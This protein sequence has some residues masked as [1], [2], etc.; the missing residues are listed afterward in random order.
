MCQVSWKLLLLLLQGQVTVHLTHVSSSFCIDGNRVSHHKSQNYWRHCRSCKVGSAC[1]E[2]GHL[3][4]TSGWVG[5]LR[6]YM[7]QHWVSHRQ[8]RA[9]ACYAE[10]IYYIFSAQK[11]L[12]GSSFLSLT[13]AHGVFL[14]F[15]FKIGETE[16][17]D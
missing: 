5:L 11:W 1:P 10:N 3:G 14:A 15:C 8:D 12:L 16:T 17:W 13:D 6:L 9:A 2:S 7:L 4:V